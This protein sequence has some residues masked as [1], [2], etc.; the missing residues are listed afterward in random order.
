MSHRHL[1]F[2]RES[3]LDLESTQALVGTVRN[4]YLLLICDLTSSS[5]VKKNIT[6]EKKL[7]GA[8]L[9]FYFVFLPCML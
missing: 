1:T 7:G 3:L 2:T 9:I 5:M 6:L 8:S 4:L